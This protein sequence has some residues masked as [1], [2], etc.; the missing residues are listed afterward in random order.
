MITAQR[1]MVSLE[2]D[3]NSILTE[4]S[5]IASGLADLLTNM[6]GDKEKAKFMIDKCVDLG[7]KDDQEIHKEAMEAVEDVNSF[8]ESLFGRM[9]M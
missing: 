6:Y 3:E 2:G 4:F 9:C 8:I 5:L 7:F 1:N